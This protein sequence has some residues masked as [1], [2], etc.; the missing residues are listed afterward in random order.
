MNTHVHYIPP[1]TERMCLSVRDRVVVA[2][3]GGS[4]SLVNYIQMFPRNRPIKKKIRVD[5][6]RFRFHCKANRIACKSEVLMTF[7]EEDVSEA[8]ERDV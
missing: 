1:K 7:R 6:E 2:C 8:Q 4:F 3:G 5:V